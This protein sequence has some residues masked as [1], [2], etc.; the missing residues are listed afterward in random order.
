MTT[1]PSSPYSPPVPKPQIPSISWKEYTKDEYRKIVQCLR[2][3]GN[4]ASQVAMGDLLH[5]MDDSN[6]RRLRLAFQ[7]EFKAALEAWTPD[8]A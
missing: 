1:Y 7:S 4:S 5:L 2:R 8:M 3:F 6:A